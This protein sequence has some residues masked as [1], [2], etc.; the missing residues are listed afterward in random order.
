MSYKHCD[1][2]HVIDL[3]FANLRLLAGKSTS[4]LNIVNQTRARISCYINEENMSP[5]ITGKS[6]AQQYFDFRVY[7]FNWPDDAIE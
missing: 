6:L 5:V 3:Q 1:P 2:G 7:I 4:I